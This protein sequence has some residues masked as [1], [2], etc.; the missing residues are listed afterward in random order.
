M[1]ILYG[2]VSIGLAR[3][4]FFHAE[5]VDQEHLAACHA[6]IGRSDPAAIHVLIQDGTGFH[7]PGG[8]PQLPANVRVLTLPA[9]Q[10]RAQPGGKALGPD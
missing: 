4:K 8:H 9:L 2:A 5:A 10:P 7:L 1:G 3:S 6:Q